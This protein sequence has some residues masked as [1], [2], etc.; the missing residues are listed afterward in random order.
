[1]AKHFSLQ[2]SR[3]TVALYHQVRTDRLEHGP[4]PPAAP[5]PGSDPGSDLLL[6]LHTRLDHVQASLA[7]FQGQ[8]QQELASISQV[9][10][11]RETLG[12]TLGQ[13]I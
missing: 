2:P 13:T 3:E 10:T 8:V 7:A 12:Q 5:R 6:G 11:G 9:L 4:R 1:M